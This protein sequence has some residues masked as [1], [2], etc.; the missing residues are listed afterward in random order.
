MGPAS[1]KDNEAKSKMKHPLDMPTPDVTR[2]GIGLGQLLLI[3]KLCIIILGIITLCV[4]MPRVVLSCVRCCYT[5][6]LYCCTVSGQSPT[7][8]LVL[9]L[10]YAARCY[11]IGYYTVIFY[12]VNFNIVNLFTC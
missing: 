9:F 12:I 11:T 7:L 4:V 10:P 5:V 2:K 6:L 1:S 8:F 3:V